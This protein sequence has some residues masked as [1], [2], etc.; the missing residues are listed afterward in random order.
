M[1]VVLRDTMGREWPVLISRH[2]K[3]HNHKDRSDMT[4]GWKDFR[5][6]NDIVDGDI[7]TFT[8]TETPGGWLLQV[9]VVRVNGP[10]PS[11][12]RP[13]GRPKREQRG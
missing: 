3:S 11:L 5:A 6:A 12:P 9:Q 13:C 7:C 8:H 4:K 2:G 10:P 1:C